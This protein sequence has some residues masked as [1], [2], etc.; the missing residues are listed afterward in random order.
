MPTYHSPQNK[1]S[2]DAAESLIMTV[3]SWAVG[4]EEL[5]LAAGGGNCALIIMAPSGTGPSRPPASH[6]TNL[7]E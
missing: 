1:P 3:Q 7:G 2:L 5:Y 4:D 6:R